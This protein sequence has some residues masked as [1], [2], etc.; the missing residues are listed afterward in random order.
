MK[1]AKFVAYKPEKDEFRWAKSKTYASP[2][3]YVPTPHPQIQ[4]VN[5]AIK[6]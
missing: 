1:P 6:K 3:P 5:E 2:R 4:R